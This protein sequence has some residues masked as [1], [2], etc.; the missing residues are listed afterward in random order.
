MNLYTARCLAP[1]TRRFDLPNARLTYMPRGWYWKLRQSWFR[2]A[3]PTGG[4]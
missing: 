1:V 2:R 3:R 4:R